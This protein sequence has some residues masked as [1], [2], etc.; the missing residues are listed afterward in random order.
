MLSYCFLES[1]W[2]A[3]AAGVAC[4]ISQVATSPVAFPSSFAPSRTVARGTYGSA[5]VVGS[6]MLKRVVGFGPTLKAPSDVLYPVEKAV[7]AEAESVI[8]ESLM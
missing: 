5:T 1:T 3:N 8:S 2:E 7:A 4:G 6:M